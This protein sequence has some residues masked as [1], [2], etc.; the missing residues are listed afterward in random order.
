M[1]F[2]LG[3]CSIRL[4]CLS[5]A[6]EYE[7]FPLAPIPGPWIA[8]LQLTA[9]VLYFVAAGHREDRLASARSCLESC[10]RYPIEPL[11]WTWDQLIQQT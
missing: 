6:A 1:R 7:T 3:S 10:R 5:H 8:S 2:G 9:A 4:A 11:A